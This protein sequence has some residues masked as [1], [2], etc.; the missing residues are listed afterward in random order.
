M[1]TTAIND[2]VETEASDLINEPKLW[3]DKGWTARVIKNEDDEGWAVEMTKD[4]EAEPALVGPG[5]MGRDKKIPSRSMPRRSV[6]WSRPPRKCC[7]VTSNICMRCST[8]KSR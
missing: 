4:G 2:P 8:R 5:T 3:R 1:T 7:V 6:R